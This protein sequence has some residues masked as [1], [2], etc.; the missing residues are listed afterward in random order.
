M[1]Y[2]VQFLKISIH[3]NPYMYKPIGRWYALNK[4]V[5][6]QVDKAKYL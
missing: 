2:D 5:Y 6:T 4:Q 1:G 3:E